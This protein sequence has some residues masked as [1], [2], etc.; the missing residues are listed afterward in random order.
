MQIDAKPL[1]EILTDMIASKSGFSSLAVE[2]MPS[3][4]ILHRHTLKKKK[5]DKQIITI[6]EKMLTDV[7]TMNSIVS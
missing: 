1:Q 4:T 5:W 6:V 2:S 7:R 3:V